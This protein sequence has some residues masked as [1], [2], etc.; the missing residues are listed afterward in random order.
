DERHHHRLP[1]PAGRLFRPRLPRRL[2]WLDHPALPELRGSDGRGARRPSGARHA[3]LR[4]LPRR[5]GARHPPLPAGQ[6]P[7]G[8]GRA[9][10]AGGALPPGAARRDALHLEARAQPP[11]GAGAGARHPARASVDAGDRGGHGRRRAPRRRDGRGGGRGHRQRP[12]RRDLRAAHPAP[13]RGGRVAQHHALLR[14]RP[15]AADAPAGCAGLR[16][17]LRF[18]RPQHTRR[19]LQGAGRFRH[20]RREHDQAGE[21]HARRRVHRHAIP[22]RRGR[23]SGAPRGEAGAGGVGLLLARAAGAGDL[24]RAPLPGGTPRGGGRL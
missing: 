23:P 21:L 15:R 22:G 13:Q 14:L 6:R 19:A 7:F 5:P 12:R 8:G 1:R 17:D 2:P 4:E 3:A 18:P 10:R 11:R 24:S 16:D 20:Q 9:L